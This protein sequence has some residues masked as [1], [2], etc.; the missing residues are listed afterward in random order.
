MKQAFEIGKIN[1]SFKAS[2]VESEQSVI[3]LNVTS[4]FSASR[5]YLAAT[6]KG[7]LKALSLR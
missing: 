4:N 3:N 7:L 5:L 6:E 2:G 1:E